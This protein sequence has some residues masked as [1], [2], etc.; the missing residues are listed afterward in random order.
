MSDTVIETREL[1]KEFTRDEFRVVALEGVNLEVRKGEFVALMG[2]S[3]S[4]KSTLL[5]LIAAMDRPTAGEIRVLGHSLREL[6]ERQI[7]HWRNEHVG[8]V[9]QQFNLIPVLTALENVELPL[10]LTNLTKAARLE[11]AATA[12][13]LVGLGDRLHHFPRQLSGGQEQRVAI[14][15]AIVTDPELILA[16]EPTGNLDAASAAEILTV[17][18]RLNREFGKTVIMVTH[19]PHAAEHASLVHHLE[20]GRLMAA[21][22]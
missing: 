7:A 10:K 22:A 6:N 18:S 9:F 20:K 2:P 13:K 17:L 12:L 15:R 1:G 19:D 8:F 5:Y 4:G 11:H 3:G 14:A 16:D 21:G